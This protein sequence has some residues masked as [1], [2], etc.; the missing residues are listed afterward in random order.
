MKGRV[1]VIIS[2]HSDRKSWILKALS[3]F[4]IFTFLLTQSDVQLVF[5]YGVSPN[6]N[7]PLPDLSKNEKIHYLTDLTGADAQSKNSQNPLQKTVD[8]NA[9]LQVDK[10]TPNSTA[11]IPQPFDVQNPLGRSNDEANLTDDL[12]SGIKVLTY[13]D[14]TYFK[15]DNKTP[16]KN[17]TEIC[18]KVD[19]N[20]EIRQFQYNYDANTVTIISSGKLATAAVDKTD[21]ADYQTFSINKADGTLGQLIGSGVW[22]WNPVK[23]QKNEIPSF[24]NLGTTS[25]VYTRDPQ[26][27]FFIKT[28]YE[29]L[30]DA[31]RARLIS[32]EKVTTDLTTGTSST[33]IDLDI[34]YDDARRTLT[35]VDRSPSAVSAGA[36][37]YW[38]YALGANNTRG[39]LIAWGE[40]EN[41][42][43]G[44]LVLSR[45]VSGDSTYTL[46]YPQHAEQLTVFEKTPGG[47]FGRILEYKT[48]SVWLKYVYEAASPGNQGS[49]TVLNYI[50]NTFI[51]MELLASPAPGQTSGVIDL[52]EKNL[53]SAGTFTATTPP[54]YKI[55]LTRNSE[56]WVV[57]DPNN[58][59]IFDVYNSFPSSDWGG[60]I[61]SRGPPSTGVPP[62]DLRFVYSS[63]V[64]AGFS[65]S[66]P[67]VYAYD[68]SSGLYALYMKQPDSQAYR[69]LEL[70][71]LQGNVSGDFTPND[72]A[73]L[74]FENITVLNTSANVSGVISTTT[75]SAA[76]DAARAALAGSNLIEAG[77]AMEPLRVFMEADKLVVVI[78]VG[79]T[80]FYYDYDAAGTP[81]AVLQKSRKTNADG[82]FLLTTFDLQGRKISESVEA[83]D[84]TVTLK[85][86][87]RYDRPNGLLVIDHVNHTLRLQSLN[88]DGTVAAT[89]QAGFYDDAAKIYSLQGATDTEA[90]WYT[91]GADDILM[92][93]DDSA[94]TRP[95]RGFDSG[96]R[97][98]G[99]GAEDQ[100]LAEIIRQLKKKSSEFVDCSVRN[101][102]SEASRGNECDEILGTIGKLQKELNDEPMLGGGGGKGNEQDLNYHNP[103][104]TPP[105]IAAIIG[106]GS[107]PILN[108]LAD[109]PKDASGQYIVDVN[110]NM[111]MGLNGTQQIWG[112]GADGVWGSGDD[113]L[114]R[115]TETSSGTTWNYENGRVV[116]AVKII[117]GQET[118]LASYAYDLAAKTVTVTQTD[119]SSY[120]YSYKDEKDPFGTGELVEARF[121]QAG[122][123][124]TQTYNEG[125]LIS[126]CASENSCT[127]Y[128]Y[129]L[130]GH[131]ATLTSATGTRVVNM[132]L[133][134]Q[135]GT[136]DDYLIGGTDFNGGTVSITTSTDEHGNVLITDTL[137]NTSTLITYAGGQAN[138][139]TSRTNGNGVVLN[140]SNI[141]VNLGADGK[142]GTADD[143][144]V[145]VDAYVGVPVTDASGRYLRADGTVALTEAEAARQMRHQL[146]LY[147]WEE[148][149]IDPAG[150][151]FTVSTYLVKADGRTLQDVMTY[152]IGADGVAGTA[153]DLLTFVESYDPVNKIRFQQQY[154][155]QGRV[156][157]YRNLETGDMLRYEFDDA[158]NQ[159]TITSSG[160]YFKQVYKFDAAHPGEFAFARLVEEERDGIMRK[161]DESEQLIS[162][163]DL[164]T[165]I[166]TKSSSSKAVTSVT[167]KDGVTTFFQDGVI[168]SV[169]K[170]DGTVLRSF[171]HVVDPV[172]GELTDVNFE[173]KATL[174]NVSIC[175]EKSGGGCSSYRVVYQNGIILEYQMKNDRPV[176]VWIGDPLGTDFTQTIDPK[177]GAM[178]VRYSD[179]RT[180]FYSQVAGFYEIQRSISLQG[181]V[182]DYCY[183]GNKVGSACQAEDPVQAVASIQAA[184][185]ALPGS[186]VD[187]GSAEFKVP[188]VNDDDPGLD[189]SV[190]Q[191]NSYQ[192]NNQTIFYAPRDTKDWQEIPETLFNVTANGHVTLY[193]LA[194]KKLTQTIE[195]RADGSLVNVSQF[196]ENGRVTH[197]YTYNQD[198]SEILNVSDSTYVSD[199]KENKDFRLLKEV[200]VRNV[201][202]LH[203]KNIKDLSAGA[204]WVESQS[205][206]LPPPETSK[207]G[208]P[209]ISGRFDF[210]RLG[211]V[212][213]TESFSHPL[214]AGGDPVFLSSVSQNYMA[215][216][217]QRSVTYKNLDGAAPCGAGF[218][219]CEITG[220]DE[221]TYVPGTNDVDFTKQFRVD[222][223]DISQA[224]LIRVFRTEEVDEYTSIIHDFGKDF[225]EDTSDDTLE[226]SL[227]VKVGDDLDHDPSRAAWGTESYVYGGV[228]AGAD[229]TL[230]HYKDIYKNGLLTDLRKHSIQLDVHNDGSVIDSKTFEIIGGRETG[231]TTFT[232]TDKRTGSSEGYDGTLAVTLLAGLS[233]E[234][235]QNFRGQD[236]F[237]T[238]TWDQGFDVPDVQ[239]D[240]RSQS[241]SVSSRDEKLTYSASKDIN[242]PFKV[243][244]SHTLVVDPTS[245]GYDARR[246][247]L[248]GSLE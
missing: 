15:Y 220:Y 142:L 121:S 145:S 50:A 52:Q 132:G 130:A 88:S 177:T 182:E 1:A 158:K 196:D 127:T 65:S 71:S 44:A 204:G 63:L 180:S 206:Y 175:L 72:P 210:L 116:S 74:H 199:D 89:L 33:E 216:Q 168:L 122:V 24:I 19:G 186:G 171:T 233:P 69:L 53:L 167:D 179:G 5:A 28:V 18:D 101:S 48:D 56:G 148:N 164:A 221:P 64:P 229:T 128:A 218:S 110:G 209:V 156:T 135:L 169:I 10:L 60:L 205:H 230:G 231:K 4:V 224:I 75:L 113:Q 85:F 141:T 243:T 90:K 247:G 140:I 184:I 176:L 7:L 245:S 237:Y 244:Y 174:P 107:A 61:R 26:G 106:L 157:L 189:F 131:T 37:P 202:D 12:V 124:I 150:T 203:I 133:D 225:K 42:T 223:N 27:A 70:G 14:G 59:Q 193:Q 54:T 161:W 235:L 151:S 159:V 46:T 146:T 67:V 215:F 80:E 188:V 117:G 30:D 192:G 242:E 134:G 190:R 108:P 13:S 136:G 29:N 91:Y 79:N 123:Q 114:V 172:T 185:D 162:T 154:D 77:A 16:N 227:K 109:V 100:R 137:Q 93:T 17:I 119:G 58:S 73:A 8:P 183:Y 25:T 248:L 173:G 94:T 40:M 211:L 241:F 51:K 43:T 165:G 200:K 181:E 147:K 81:S 92:N 36:V 99:A 213:Y 129:D 170:R 178:T 144:Y 38:E 198:G 98:G 191:N 35:V 160:N 82:T 49:V 149:A 153:D 23:D 236:Y 125:R 104:P 20:F 239:R 120:K 102:L 126:S 240:L 32:Y 163:T 11:T 197:S 66:S 152:K 234:E 6:A 138:I 57:V 103:A 166:E 118:P 115:L 232:E 112:R 139:V 219:G 84:G 62:V 55:L 187:T 78:K 95:K 228:A 212:D 97:R 194:D 39:V 155:D 105:Y 76:L 195:Q 207:E 2:Y 45:V 208:V 21:L 246:A 47:A 96:N 111:T 22:N 222:H 83:A 226:V 86:S 31:G 87:Y 3:L 9:K 238:R 41:K 201:A 214:A 68:L 34:R 143:R 217:L